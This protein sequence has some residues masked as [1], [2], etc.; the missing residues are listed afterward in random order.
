[1]TLANKLTIA[2]LVLIPVLL[3][4]LAS[5]VPW[6]GLLAAILF[7]VAAVTDILDGKIARSAHT[8]TDFGKIFDPIADKLLV[9]AALL[10]LT[11]AGRVHWA[12]TFIILGRELAISGFRIVAA[13]KGIPVIAASSLGKLK[14]VLTD[15]AIVMML[16]EDTLP[17]LRTWWISDAVMLAAVVLTVVSMMDYFVKNRVAMQ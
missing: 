4:V 8:V 5:S 14:T 12:V 3:G 16:L 2:R 13:A 11:A 7:V 1:M 17:F 10:P 9:L 15:V 6:S